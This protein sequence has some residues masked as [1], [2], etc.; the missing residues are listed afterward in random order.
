MCRVLR[1]C[2]GGCSATGWRGARAGSI[3]LKL[4]ATTNFAERGRDCNLLSES[5]NDPRMSIFGT[6]AKPAA[7]A[8]VEVSQP[9]PGPSPSP[10]SSTD[11]APRPNRA[12]RICLSVR[13]SNVCS[14]RTRSPTLSAACR[15]PRRPTCSPWEAGT[16]KLGSSRSDKAASTRER[17]VTRTK[18][19]G[20]QWAR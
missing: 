8:D 17:L 4:G 12:D 11:I 18:V 10:L 13:T 14:S 7:P 15:G 16:T 20:P 6:A 5:A 2:G 1:S 3:G 9:C 19:S